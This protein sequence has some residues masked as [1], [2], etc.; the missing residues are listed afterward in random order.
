[1]AEPT[2]EEHS[3][4]DEALAPAVAH[5]DGWIAA[6]GPLSP[7]AA[8]VLGIDLCARAA[9]MPD[10]E[11][12][13]ALPTLRT[14]AIRRT[15]DGQWRWEPAT[16]DPLATSIRPASVSAGREIPRDNQAPEH[17]PFPKASRRHPHR[18]RLDYDVVERIG[19]VLYEGVSGQP[20]QDRFPDEAGTRTALRRL[21]PDLPPAVV[22]LIARAASPRHVTV[23]TIDR[24]ARELRALLGVDE[25]TSRTRVSR[26]VGLA[27]LVA[28]GVALTLWGPGR[29]GSDLPGSNGL[30]PRE[31]AL[32]EVGLE[33]AHY[34]AVID[35]HSLS[36]QELQDLERLLRARVPAQDPRTV[37]IAMA[38]AWVR[39]LRGDAL[40]A[41]QLLVSAPSALDRTLG[42]THP[43]TRL[44]HQQL[45]AVQEAR[46][47]TSDADQHRVA[48][49]RALEALITADPGLRRIGS[50]LNPA[51][52]MPSPFSLLAHVAP[53]P[54]E[55]EGFRQASAD[56]PG[57]YMV[58]LTS[59][60]R[61]LAGRD[62]WSLVVRADGTCRV[63]A[64]FGRDARR[65]GVTIEPTL[66]GAWNVSMPGTSPPLDFQ[67]PARSTAS[68][69]V[70]VASSGTVEATT[71]NGDRRQSA[72]DRSTDGPDPPYSLGFSS[73][74]PSGGCQLVW[75]QL[76]E[77]R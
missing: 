20:L 17:K 51:A 5:L 77:P 65:I 45:A 9:S 56:E 36:L 35:E 32:H 15:R 30:T 43:Y 49:A 39:F 3:R 69:L 52:N 41:E 46:G 12:L 16:A 7:P 10:D 21:R 29:G 11:L 70:S 50:S 14:S 8:A 75:W 71:G 58:A 40:T 76:N 37:F 2:L 48:A 23:S 25:P 6:H 44:A 26:R 67:M 73:D 54:P 27:A 72:V 53:S 55:L 61:W 42:E 22:K 28:L 74:P 62:G 34:L 38:Q 13:A 24:L 66:S 18:T 57:R 60:Q 63:S 33:Q 19:A 4:A 68:L 31:T 1:M 47:A 59:T 64:D